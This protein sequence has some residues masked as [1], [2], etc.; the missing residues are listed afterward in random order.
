MIR[1]F[2]A[3]FLACLTVAT[4]FACMEAFAPGSDPPI[5]MLIRTKGT[6]DIDHAVKAIDDLK[7]EGVRVY[8]V[9]VP[10]VTFWSFFWRA[11]GMAVL[12]ALLTAFV[13]FF[14]KLFCRWLVTAPHL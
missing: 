3:F 1:P 12:I 4:F 6:V 9:D 11:L 7:L 13:L 5:R 8:K 10:E 2:L 14:Y